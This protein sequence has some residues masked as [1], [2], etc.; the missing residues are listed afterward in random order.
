MFLY[1]D[2]TGKFCCVFSLLAKPLHSLKFKKIKLHENE[3]TFS[4][5]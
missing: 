5:M 2:M 1:V 3:I 4:F